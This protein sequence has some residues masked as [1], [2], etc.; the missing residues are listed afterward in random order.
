M[1]AQCVCVFVCAQ[2]THTT[3]FFFLDFLFSN[4]TSVDH[5]PGCHYTH[6]FPRLIIYVTETLKKQQTNNGNNSPSLLFDVVGL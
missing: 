2:A 1:H 4:K 6:A 3:P 5:I